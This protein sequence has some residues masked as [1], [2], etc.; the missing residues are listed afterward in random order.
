MKLRLFKFAG[1]ILGKKKHNF[2]TRGFKL[3]EMDN[4]VYLRNAASCVFCT[5]CGKQINLIG[6]ELSELTFDELYG[7][8]GTRPVDPRGPKGNEYGYELRPAS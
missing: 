1:Y 5:C 8:P 2:I 3:V 6:R 7:C 4:V